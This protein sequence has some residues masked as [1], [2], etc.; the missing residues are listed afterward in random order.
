[1]NESQAVGI[2]GMGAVS[3]YGWGLQK[4]W[5]GLISG[6]SAAEPFKFDDVSGQVV[7]VPEGGEEDDSITLFGRALYGSGREAVAEVIG[8][9]MRLRRAVPRHY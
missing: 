2:V 3:G 7:L 1:M 5:D 9:V 4:L 8:Y 6:K